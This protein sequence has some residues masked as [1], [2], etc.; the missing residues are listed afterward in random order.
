[1]KK[2]L[3]KGDSVIIDGKELTKEKIKKLMTE[4]IVLK[5]Q[6]NFVRT[7][8]FLEGSVSE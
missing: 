2:I 3:K 4:N 7:T 1:M 5:R 8:N 6:I